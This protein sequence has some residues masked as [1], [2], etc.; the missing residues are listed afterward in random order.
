[1]GTRAP[2]LLCLLA[3]AALCD[4]TQGATPTHYSVPFNRTIF[5]TGFIFG[6]GSAAY[7]VYI[8]MGLV[9]YS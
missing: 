1:M 7:Q 8:V 6:A 5:P 4:S 9:C 3:L 2:F